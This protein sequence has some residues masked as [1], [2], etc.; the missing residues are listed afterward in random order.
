MLQHISWG[1]FAQ[2]MIIL[3]GGYYLVI[4]P[5]YYRKELVNFLRRRKGLPLT[6]IGLQEIMRVY[7]QVKNDIAV[8]INAEV[9]RM[10]A[11]PDLVGLMGVGSDCGQ[12][13]AVMRKPV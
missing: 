11:D 6:I 10:A 13:H 1:Q 3:T 12:P 2:A 8:M 5:L 7:M 9:G 4:S